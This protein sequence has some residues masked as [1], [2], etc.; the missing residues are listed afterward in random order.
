[1]FAEPVTALPQRLEAPTRM[2]DRIQRRNHRK[3]RAS[4]WFARERDGDM[5]AFDFGGVAAGLG[6]YLDAVRRESALRRAARAA[7]RAA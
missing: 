4:S 5:Q 6:A 1:M 7:A 2:F 3:A